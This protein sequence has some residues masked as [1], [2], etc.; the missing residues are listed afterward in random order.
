LDQI[1]YNQVIALNMECV[2]Q[3]TFILKS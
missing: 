1:L 2:I 3:E